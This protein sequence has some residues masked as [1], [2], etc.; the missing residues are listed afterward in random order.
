MCGT[1]LRSCFSQFNALVVSGRDLKEIGLDA[2]SDLL[3][4]L[5]QLVTSLAS[6]VGI[7]QTIQ[8]AAQRTLTCGWKVL[9]PSLQERAVILSGLLPGTCKSWMYYRCI[10][11]F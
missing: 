6:N 9:I 8:A 5:R 3:A 4:S 10:P 7:L 1:V 11:S 2:G